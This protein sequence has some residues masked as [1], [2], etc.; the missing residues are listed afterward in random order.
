MLRMKIVI[1]ALITCV[2]I[3]ILT[4]GCTTPP[5]PATP[6]PTATP[7]PA[8]TTRGPISD[9]Q[10]VGNWTLSLL[11]SQGGQSVQTTFTEPI[12]ITIYNQGV[13]AGYSGCNN[14]QGSYTLT[15]VSGPFGKEI[16]IGPVI[17]TQKYCIGTSDTE[18]LYFQILSSVT[19]YG[20]DTPTKLSMRDPLGNTLVFVR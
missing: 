1:A 7:A 5:V 17:A 12:T 18:T 14:Y 4:A 16:R 6:T 3:A 13:F 10:L 20:I 11:G 19:T 15:G 2:T 9:P 8:V